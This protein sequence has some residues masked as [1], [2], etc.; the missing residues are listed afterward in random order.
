MA[1]VIADGAPTNLLSLKNETAYNPVTRLSDQTAGPLWGYYL[2]VAAFGIGQL[3]AMSPAL[4]PGTARLF[5]ATAQQDEFVPWVQAQQMA[6]AAGSTALGAYADVQQLAAGTAAVTFVHVSASTGTGVSQPAYNDYLVRQLKAV[7]PV[8]ASPGETSSVIND[9]RVPGWGGYSIGDSTF[10]TTLRTADA[11]SSVSGRIT[12]APGRSFKLM[13]CV[14]YFDPVRA[15]MSACNQSLV[16]TRG[17]L[18]ETSAP[19]PAAT[20][21]WLRPAAGTGNGFAYAVVWLWHLDLTNQWV[22]IATSMPDRSIDSGA[23]VPPSIG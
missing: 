19:L 7:A 23:S 18:G 20:A 6:T 8:V 3:D 17:K 1:C 9:I 22:L 4:H 16:D 13:S 11:Q 14:A 12:L 10:E 21:T 2:A 15:P 5:L